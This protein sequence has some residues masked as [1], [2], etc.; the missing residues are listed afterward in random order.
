V[1]KVNIQ[2]FDMWLEPSKPGISREL[3][4]MGGREHAFMW[5]LN[6]EVQGCSVGYDVGGNIGYTTLPIAKAC[7]KVYAFE[8]DARSRRL[9]KL[10][11]LLNDFAHVEVYKEAVWNHNLGVHFNLSSRPNQS[12][13]TDKGVKV[14]SVTLDTFA[15]FSDTGIFVKADIEG[16]EIEMLE[17][18]KKL[19]DCKNVK[20]LMELHGCNYRKSWRLLRDYGFWLKY[21]VNA[22]GM[23]GHF[24][25]HG[26]GP[27]VTFPN[28]QR[29]VY[30]AL[31]LMEDWCSEKIKGKKI[32]R[33]VLWVK[34]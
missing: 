12:S 33:S 8:P 25:E 5:I 2:G 22:K 32:V 17:G 9:L 4:L 20:I 23:T 3:Y 28:Y 7:E 11:L 19:L 34:D 24:E 18:A 13:V 26:F 10:N 15:K 1:K 16:A 30:E 31:P 14:P 6:K 29:A 21:V 27:I